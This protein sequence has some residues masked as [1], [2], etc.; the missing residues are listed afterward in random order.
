M[1]DVSIIFVNYLSEDYLYNSLKSIYQHTSNVSFEIIVIDNHFIEGKNKEILVNF[2]HVIWIQ[3][4][5]NIGFGKANNLGVEHAKG[6]YILFLN[7]DTLVFDNAI[8]N[9]FS[10]LENNSKF[11]AIGGI[12]V[13]L[14]HKKIP[15]YQSLND[16][17]KDLYFIPQG[18]FFK[19]I[20][21]ALLPKES[22][23]EGETNN[24]GGAFILV[25]KEIFEKAGKWDED[26]FMY[27]EDAELSYRLHQFGKLAYSEDVKFI[28]LIQG[29][30]FTRAND[31]WGNRFSVQ[32]QVS[33]FLWIRKCYGLFPLILI[34]LNYIL[35]LP[36]FWGW[37]LGNNL[38][39]GKKLFDDLYNQKMISKKIWILCKYLPK[40]LFPNGKNFQILPEENIGNK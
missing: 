24:L 25:P 20:L 27:A 21:F 4:V 29:N 3:S 17:R 40:Y 33:N 32:I 13:D 31:S 7:C 19:K 36:I 34:Y 16:I 23:F 12:Q 10:F 6:K 39:K 37:K 5:G 22:F 1:I 9:A 26:F 15:F 8:F 14:S 38:T 35:F 11:V 30:E 2:P 18:S 28:H